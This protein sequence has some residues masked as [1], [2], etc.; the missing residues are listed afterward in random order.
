MTTAFYI[1]GDFKRN[2]ITVRA[3]NMTFNSLSE[4]VEPCVKKR[5]PDNITFKVAKGK[6]FFDIIN[7]HGAE[8]LSF[9]S[10]R[11]IDLLSEFVD[12]SDKC[13]PIN[14][15]GIEEKYYMIYNLPEYKRLNRVK[16]EVNPEEPLFF[17]E[18]E[19]KSPLFS[20]EGG[21][22]FIVSEDIMNHLIKNKISNAFFRAS[23]I[24]TEEEYK[25]WQKNQKENFDFKYGDIKFL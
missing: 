6:K 16:F 13:Y 23:Y 8:N 20:Y 5:L 14:I 7:Y 11:F 9:Y 18:K 24:S 4:Y 1:F 3:T 22:K 10:Q 17:S 19:M 12:M 21:N 15:E 2:H 25:D